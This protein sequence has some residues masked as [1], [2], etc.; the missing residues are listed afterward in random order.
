MTDHG[1]DVF[2]VDHLSQHAAFFTLEL[3]KPGLGLNLARQGQELAKLDLGRAG[4]D[5]PLGKSVV[6]RLLLGG[7]RWTV[8]CRLGFP[9]CAQPRDSSSRSAMRSTCTL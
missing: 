4:V 3:F 7:R 6:E 2:V 5:I 9:L 8:E 1:G